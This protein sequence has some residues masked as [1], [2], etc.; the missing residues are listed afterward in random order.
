[1]QNRH[2]LGLGCEWDFV[3]ARRLRVEI[4]LVQSSLGGDDQRAFSGIALDVPPPIALN[5]PGVRCQRGGNRN[6]SS[7]RVMWH[8]ST[9]N[10]RA[11]RSI[12]GRPPRRASQYVSDE[13]GTLPSTTYNP[14]T[15]IMATGAPCAASNIHPA[16]PRMASLGVRVALSCANPLQGGI[17]RLT[18][19]PTPRH[20]QLSTMGGR[21]GGAESH[22]RSAGAEEFRR[23]RAW[24]NQAEP[25]PAG[26]AESSICSHVSVKSTVSLSAQPRHYCVR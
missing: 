6:D 21:T 20:T 15:K 25:A 8:G 5:D 14:P 2:T 16:R 23:D 12:T 3:H 24:C 4:A 1:M 18:A 11:I 26:I 7:A 19:K 9:R 17:A 13:P 10:Q 22:A